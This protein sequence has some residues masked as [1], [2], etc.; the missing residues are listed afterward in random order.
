MRE[1]FGE[2]DEVGDGDRGTAT[3]LQANNQ[4]GFNEIKRESKIG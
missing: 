1:R 2:R 3:E 4:I